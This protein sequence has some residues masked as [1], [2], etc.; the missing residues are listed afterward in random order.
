MAY[1]SIC[2]GGSEERQVRFFVRIKR[3]FLELHLVQPI[4][5]FNQKGRVSLQVHFSVLSY[6]AAVSPLA[7]ETALGM[8]YTSLQYRIST[9]F[10]IFPKNDVCG[11]GHTSTNNHARLFRNIHFIYL[12]V[13]YWLI[14]GLG[15]LFLHFMTKTS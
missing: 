13:G 5:R 8:G 7:V 15:R 6:V 1:F 11:Q 3:G 14:L 10:L 9:H 2:L 12:A 4:S